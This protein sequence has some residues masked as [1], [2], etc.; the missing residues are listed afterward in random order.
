[1]R[2]SARITWLAMFSILGPVSGLVGTVP[3]TSSPSPSAHPSIA[4]PEYE[5]LIQWAIG[6]Y[7]DAGLDLGGVTIGVYDDMSVCGADRRGYYRDQT[8]VVCAVHP[9][10]SV[11]EAWRRQ[12]LLHEVAHAWID[13]GLDVERRERFMEWRAA[14]TWMSRDHP[15][16]ERGVEHAA[17]AVAWGVADQPYHPH[18]ALVDRTCASLRH[19]FELLTGGP[20]LRGYEDHCDG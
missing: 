18:V 8:V 15:W 7:A 11:Q 2:K 12:T 17:E 9:R 16:H 4:T 5:G 6:V 14:V 3:T 13:I 10:S 20:P 1:M 19:G